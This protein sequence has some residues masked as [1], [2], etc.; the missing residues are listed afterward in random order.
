MSALSGIHP[1]LTSTV[2]EVQQSLATLKKQ[3]DEENALQLSLLEPNT[4]STASLEKH[5]HQFAPL[6]LVVDRATTRRLS[7]A[8]KLLITCSTLY[9]AH[10]VVKQAEA[11]TFAGNVQ[12]KISQSLITDKRMYLPLPSW[13]TN[14]DAVLIQAIAKHGWIEYDACCRAITEDK[15][16]KWGAPFDSVADKSEQLTSAG[17]DVDVLVSVAKR[18]SQFLTTEREILDALKDFKVAIL[19]KTFSLKKLHATEEDN[20][21]LW[22]VD[23]SVLRGSPQAEDGND[24]EGDSV[25]LPT[26]KDLVKRAKTILARRIF[27][28]DKPLAEPEIEQKADHEYYILDQKDLSNVFLVEVLRSLI[29]VSFN[30]S[31]KRRQMGRRLM[32]T[33]INEAK[34]RIEDLEAAQPRDAAA[35]DG[36]TKI[37]DHCALANR[38]VQTLPVQAKNVLRAILGLAPV[39][40]KTGSSFFPP[41][42]PA[43][44]I[45][46]LSSNDQ[47]AASNP[48][49]KPKKQ[50]TKKQR[51]KGASGDIAISDAMATLAQD[52]AARS[53]LLSEGTHV[54]LSAPETLLLTVVCSQGLPVWTENWF[55]LVDSSNLVPEKQGPG[56]QNAISWWGMGQVFEAAANVWHHTSARKLESQQ[57]SFLERYGTVPETDALKQEAKK[58]LDVLVQDEARKRMSLAVAGDYKNNPEKLAKKCIMLMESLR[59]H[60]GPVETIV[61]KSQARAVKLNKTENGL[62]PFVLEWLTNEIRRWAGSLGLVDDRGQPFSLTAADFTPTDRNGTA[63]HEIAALMDRKC[64]RTVFAQVAQQS[65]VREVFL[66]NTEQGVK[67]LLKNAVQDFASADEWDCV[68]DWWG[69]TVEAPGSYSVEYDY[70]ILDSLLEYGYSGIEDTLAKFDEQMAQQGREV[71]FEILCEEGSLVHALTPSFTAGRCRGK[72]ITS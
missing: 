35:I 12:E 20:M 43:L 52:E 65:R 38:Y 5:L 13:T 4:I 29:K 62:G 7:L 41:E 32:N 28:S 63:L 68:P 70:R 21:T 2:E 56:F 33:A 67:F 72:A 24:G 22:E 14:H 47:D 18:A 25:E 39:T 57:S 27:L 46:S 64:C 40:P 45:E 10:D 50:R 69:K 6:Q 55:D 37:I 17:A 51:N 30:N 36:M 61:G 60:I 9:N 34:N 8:K 54:Q 15:S 42:R 23:E 58:K 1:E 19:V 11:S 44:N 31:G 3:D 71:S 49:P 66:K 53:K 48:K 16:I 59:N 26:K